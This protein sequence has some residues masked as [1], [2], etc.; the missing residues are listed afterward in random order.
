LRQIV[1]FGIRA[2]ANAYGVEG[3]HLKDVL[4]VFAL[5][6]PSSLTT[7]HLFVD[8]ETRGELT[9]GMCV[10]DVRSNASDKPN[11]HLGIGVDV[12]AVR[13]YIDETLGRAN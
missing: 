3:F 10:V 9:R 8:V 6:R 4:G 1:P 7:R 11:V 12:H 13:K 5:A 2:T